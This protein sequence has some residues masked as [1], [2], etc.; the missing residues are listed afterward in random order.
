VAINRLYASDAPNGLH[1]ETSANPGFFPICPDLQLETRN[2]KLETGNYPMSVS[3]TLSNKVALI[4]GG[5]RG[6]G[7][8]AVR[9]FTAAGAKVAF[10]Y[11][12]ARSQMQR[13]T[14]L[15]FTT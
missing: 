10:S 2:S 6:I 7:A 4:T 11:Q 9:M 14:W 15:P 3:L 5:S 13:S 12:K 1:I 8:A